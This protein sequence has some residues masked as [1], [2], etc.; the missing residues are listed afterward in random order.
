M[1]MDELQQIA[2]ARAA[3]MLRDYDPVQLVMGIEMHRRM[4]RR[5]PSEFTP[6][7]PDTEARPLG[8]ALTVKL[9]MEGFA[10]IPA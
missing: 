4:R 10:V 6:A 3:M 8:M 9:D 1:A 7:H 2:E 5:Y